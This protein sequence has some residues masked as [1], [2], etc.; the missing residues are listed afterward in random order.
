MKCSPCPLCGRCC[1]GHIRRRITAGVVDAYCT[2]GLPR[3]G[4]HEWTTMWKQ[5]HSSD[6]ESGSAPI[7][8]TSEEASGST[9][10][11]SSD[12]AQDGGARYDP[13]DL[14]DPHGP[15]RLCC[16]CSR[17]VG[18]DTDS[19]GVGHGLYR[20]REPHSLGVRQARRQMRTDQLRLEQKAEKEQKASP[21]G[22]GGRI[23]VVLMRLTLGDAVLLSLQRDRPSPWVL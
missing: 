20:V 22:P 15:W 16:L 2:H 14:G 17:L 1:T 19:H 3:M 5:P 9:C 13:G 6:A 21:Y 12:D 4:I 23:R 10:T 8:A 18:D 7:G 11:Q